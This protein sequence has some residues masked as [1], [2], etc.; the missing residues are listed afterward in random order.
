MNAQ[1]PAFGDSVQQHAVTHCL[2]LVLNIPQH[3]VEV[4]LHREFGMRHLNVSAWLLSSG[5]LMVLL[6]MTKDPT[7]GAFFLLYNLAFG[8]HVYEQRLKTYSGGYTYS[9]YNG[10][11]FAFWFE[12]PLPMEFRLTETHV[13]CI[14]E[15]L[16]LSVIGLVLLQFGKASGGVVLLL[17]SYYALRMALAR[18]FAQMKFFD[19]MDAVKIS[20]HMH[21]AVSDRLE[22]R[23]V[24]GVTLDTSLLRTDKSRNQFLAHLNRKFGLNSNGSV[25][26]KSEPPPAPPNPATRPSSEQFKR[27]NANIKPRGASTSPGV[28]C[29]HCGTATNKPLSP[30]DVFYC[31]RCKRASTVPRRDDGR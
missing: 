3:L 31:R 4:F 28:S 27:G 22:P 13:K 30:G 26:G 23:E 29:Q 1:N 6:V 16:L 8:F 5:V 9:Y 21:S 25:N 15:P 12:I 10:R 11:P 2:A 20:E 14:G 19:E 7:L 24:D 18:Y 17:A